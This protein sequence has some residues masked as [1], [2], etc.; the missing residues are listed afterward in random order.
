MIHISICMVAL[1][2]WS[3]LED[4]LES[5]KLT[6]SWLRYEV[7]LV[8]NASTDGTVEQVRAAYPDV[9]II[10]N[11]ANVGFTRATNQ[12]I[13]ASCGE[14]LLWLNTD[15]I[16]NAESLPKLYEFMQ[17]HP[18]AGIVGPRVLNPD[19]SFQPQCKRGM[20]TPLASLCYFTGIDRIWPNQPRVARY[21]L[22]HLPEDQAAQVDAVSGCCLLARRAVWEQIGALDEAIF[23]F[24]EDLDWC[25]RARDAGW[26]VWYYPASTIVHLKGQGGV[27]ARPFRKVRGM[28]QGMWV[29]YRKHLQHQYPLPVTWLVWAGIWTSFAAASL[30][31]AAA[32]SVQR[33]RS[34]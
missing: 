33:W 2:C 19:G 22:R 34:A 1:N 15:T 20:P 5:L 13:E 11:H 30:R 8:D 6:P 17:A 7:I 28:H 4:C 3:V 32:R 25:V 12:A 14:Y 23:A 10:Q 16:L 27:H 9:R 26:E 18:D 21:L 31:V 29:F 24:G